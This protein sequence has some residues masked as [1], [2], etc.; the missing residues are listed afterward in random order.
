MIRRAG[1]IF[2]S[3]DGRI[4][5]LFYGLSIAPVEL[6]DNGNVAATRQA[7]ATDGVLDGY[8]H[9]P[10]GSVNVSGGGF[11]DQQIRSMAIPESDQNYFKSVVRRLDGIIDLDFRQVGHTLIADIDLFYDTEIDP[12]G[13][14]TV[15]GLASIMVMM[16]GNCI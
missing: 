13:G 4:A 10:G 5:G 15:L 3:I 7:T 6:I 14:G 16:V 2:I 12:G 9:A 1:R 11:G 8:L